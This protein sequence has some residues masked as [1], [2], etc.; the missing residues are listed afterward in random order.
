MQSR[1]KAVGKSKELRS[2]GQPHRSGRSL[3]FQQLEPRVVLSSTPLIT[4]FMASNASTLDDGDGNSSDWIEI[5]NPTSTPVSL[6]GWHL[7]DDES[8]PA[9]WTF[10]D[11]SLAPNQYLVV[12]ASAPEDALGNVLNDYVDGEGNLHTNFRLSADGEYLGLSMPDGFGGQTVVHE[13]APEF[14]PQRSDISYGV[15]QAISTLDFIDPDS[16]VATVLIPADGSLD[17][18]SPGQAPLWTVAG[19]DDSSWSTSAPTGGTGTGFDDGDD[20]NP[21][22][23]N[24]G[25]ILPGG[26]V[27]NDLTDPEDDGDLAGVFTVGNTNSPGGEEPFRA[28]DNNVNTKWLSFSPPGT[29]YQFQFDAGPQFVNSYTIT[30]ANDADNRDPYSWT[31]SGSNDG[32]NFTVVDT[33]VAQNFAGRFETQKFDF[34]ASA[35]Y[36]YYRFDFQTEFGA[37]GS[38]QP[39]SI[40]LAE[41]ELLTDGIV[42][43]DGW[44]DIDVESDW[45]IHRTSLFERIEFTSPDP[46]TLSALQ[47]NLQYDDG[48][49]AYLNGERVAE[50]FAPATVDFNSNATAARANPDAVTVESFDLS[51]HLDKLVAGTNVLA[52]QALNVD[53]T[54][55]D[56]LLRPE[57]IATEL[58]DI[59][60][61]AGFYAEPT[62]RA[63]NNN[64]LSGLVADVEIGVPHGFYDTA[65]PLALTTATPDAEIYYTTNGE[66]P[67]PASG[68]L[69]TGP[70]SI[71]ETTSLRTAAFKQ[72]FIPSLV[73]TQTYLFVDDIVSQDYQAT[74]DA[75]FP[76]SWGPA[77]PDYGID[78]DVIGNFD[79]AG[80][81]TGGDL[82]GG[83]YAA[84]IKDDLKAIPTL[85]IVMDVDD[86]FGP[87][88]IY[89]SPTSSGVA[90]ERATSVELIH[91]DGTDGFQVDAGIRIQ[92][93]AFRRDD[94]SKKHSLRLLFKNEYGPSKLEYP[95]FGEDAADEFDTITL[96]MDSND[97]YAWNSAGSQ[98]QYARDEFGR[99]TQ[100]ALGQPASHGNRV[101]LYINGIYW[102]IYNPVE[103]PDASFSSS[104]YGG[105]RGEWD[106]LNAGDPV[107]GNLA[108]WNTLG[109]LAQAVA[110]AS[111]ESARTAAYMLLQGKNPDGTEHPTAENYLDIDNYI[112]YMLINLYGGNV[113]WPHRNWFASRQRG[114]ESTGFKFH[115]WD[116]ESA[117]NLLGNINT[118]RTGVSGNVAEPYNDLR[119]S[120]EFRLRFADR[121][122]RALFN[123]GALTS[124][125]TT[126]RYQEILDELDQA[127]VAESARWGDMHRST[128]LTKAQWVA[129]GNDVISTFIQGRTNVLLNQLRSAGLYPSINAPVFN[130]HGGSVPNGFGLSMT[131]SSGAIYYTLDGSD[132]RDIGGGISANAIQYAGGSI[133]L[134]AAV[135]VRARAYSNRT[136]SASNEASFTTELPANASNLRTAEL[137]YNPAAPS[138]A[139]INAGFT[140]KDE[141]E[142]VE[143]LNTSNASIELQGVVFSNAVDFAFTGSTVLAPGERAVVVENQDAFEFRYGTSIRVLGQ[144]SG[145]LDNGGDTLT[146]T[147]SSGQLIQSFS[148][149]DGDDPGEETWPTSP[150]GGGP[151]LVVIDVQG[152]YNDGTNWRASAGIGGSPGSAEPQAPGDYNSDGS[153]TEADY[154]LWKSTLGS[155]TDLRADG[156]G[157]QVID[158]ADY[159][160]WRDHLQQSSASSLV[161]APNTSAVQLAK[162]WPL[163][164][165][166]RSMQSKNEATDN[167]FASL[168]VADSGGATYVARSAPSDSA[169]TDAPSL[170][171]ASLAEKQVSELTLLEREEF[172]DLLALQLLG[173]L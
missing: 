88:G 26:L 163:E 92:G 119:S 166:S 1:K 47:L 147:D 14:R 117:L 50:A 46:A 72:D 77:T 62:P 120:E 37:T 149:E 67:T 34:A 123:N 85:S 133:V 159:T 97:G 15:N 141:F 125:N 57:L 7:S 165:Q 89:S 55:A 65:F 30:S 142:F 153:V 66:A 143:L 29:Y 16:S 9:K 43:F 136:W 53:D 154:T 132:P 35:L 91:P 38:N 22:P 64:N 61:Q 158:A 111:G 4:E 152:D 162:A 81:S 74:L 144:W 18:P 87:N 98:P 99:R 78:P 90:W 137:H 113:D 115:I 21:P 27:G 93:G 146:I 106:A 49:V 126:A 124:D 73:S 109:N 11:V 10:P 139:E 82:F 75:G 128:P 145:G 96:R 100:L 42:D 94:L 140:D 161:A 169:E 155:T 86:M 32:S 60:Y 130:Q 151:S 25:V 102:G 39:N 138:A 129:E 95:F 3:Q 13:Y 24:D 54:S 71:A 33:R 135:T 59:Q 172:D 103:R 17:A 112:D 52:I 6:D 167:A 80:N 83:A 131:T 148:Y 160:V 110:N 2:S 12:F 31:L 156:N 63:V 20:D 101:H 51:A 173:E 56:L 107:D 104:Y 76:T 164:L 19:F 44:I 170:A 121:A 68:T 5:H 134:D 118:N 36:E 40:Q 157:N 48:F 127:I 84:T 23:T 116:M 70:V 69:Y 168:A 108:T 114:P 171:F 45:N 105:A 79:S 8:A 41:I 58:I 122:H 150:D 28:L